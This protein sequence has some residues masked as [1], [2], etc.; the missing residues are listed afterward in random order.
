MAGRAPNKCKVS[1]EA[2]ASLD[3]VSRS[4]I[5]SIRKRLEGFDHQFALNYLG[6]RADLNFSSLTFLS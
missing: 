1:R 4:R 6:M 3:E 5:S 2:K